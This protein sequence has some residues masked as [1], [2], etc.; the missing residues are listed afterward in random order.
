MPTIAGE[1]LTDDEYRERVERRLAQ[2]PVPGEDPYTRPPPPQTP[3]PPTSSPGAGT[4][5]T[6]DAARRHAQD[7][8]DQAAADV[9]AGRRDAADLGPLEMAARDA[10]SW[11][12][13]LRGS[14]A[15][16]GVPY[17]FS[18]LERIIRNV[19]YAANAGTDPD[20]Y[21]RML[22]DWYD[23]RA[24]STSHR[25]SDSQGGA[26][27]NIGG[28][29]R[30]EPGYRGPGAPP[31]SAPPGP[32]SGGLGVG[33][34]PVSNYA[35]VFSDPL[36][37]QYER[38]LQQ[39]LA[40][41]EQQQAQ[42]RQAATQAEQRRAATGPAFRRLEGYITDRASRLQGPAYTGPEAEVLRTQLL[43]PIERDRT[44]AQRRAME[45]IGRRRLDPSY[46]LARQL[47]MDVNRGL[48]AYP[49]RAQ[50]S[51]ASRQIEEQRSR[52]QEA[53]QLLQL[54]TQ[55]PDAEAR[56]DLNF[57][58]YVQSLIN[59]PGQQGLTVGGLL[60]DLPTQRLNDALAALGIAPN[61]SNVSAQLL[62]L[63]AQ[64]QYQRQVQNQLS[65]GAWGNI[66]RSFSPAF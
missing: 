45:Q 40:A 63:L 35:A 65:A 57:V 62:Q 1:Y 24:A 53:Q 26:Y 18:D 58:N 15:S 8:Y 7:I 31:G 32:V 37:Q 4:G 33:Q 60:A 13:R 38:L 21:L 47:E 44:A 28:D 64:Q 56:G 25:T 51:I 48:D 42:L 23:A 14:A 66:G 61:A 3:R 20:R 43:D 27:P 49:T 54:L 2:D 34:A 50:G 39:Q 46:G 55:L 29:P 9:A 19:S 6:Y 11:D 16:R 36:T 17:D 59:Q 41:F 52:E 10:G 30:R 5:A 22:E 12:A